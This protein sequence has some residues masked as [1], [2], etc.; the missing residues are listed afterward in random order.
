MTVAENGLLAYEAARQADAAGRPFDLVLMD[1]QMPVLDGY[2]ATRRLRDEGYTGAIVALTAHAMSGD[3]EKCLA[4]GCDDF[5]TKPI[6]REQLF[7]VLARHVPTGPS[8][9]SIHA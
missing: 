3:R 6:S 7:D 2:D 1:M 4:A 9:A 5:V 8:A